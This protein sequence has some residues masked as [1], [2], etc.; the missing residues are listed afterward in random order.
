MKSYKRKIIVHFSSL[1]VD[2]QFLKY[3]TEKP[4]SYLLVWAYVYANISD[5]K[6]FTENYTFLLSRFKISR[7]TLQRIIDN[8]II[9][10]NS[11]TIGGQKVG[12][13][14][15]AKELIISVV[16]EDGGQKVGRKWA[17]NSRKKNTKSSEVY[18]AMIKL[19][20]DFCQREMGMG[21][22]IDGLQGKSMKSIISYLETQVK[23][24]QGE[25]EESVLNEEVI[26]AWTFI[27]TQWSSISDF[28]KAQIRLN[29]INSNL[30][31]IL[32]QLKNANSKSRA[33]KFASAAN[34][35]ANIS[36]E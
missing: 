3:L 4:H 27:L 9:F 7:T 28:Y 12:R 21:A 22:K 29:Q 25:I 24:K 36:F 30:P 2:K 10:L 16:T 34:A 31:N 15:A 19:Y 14:W 5:S 26:K 35:A 11:M 33:S 20:D 13:K 1:E 32:T 8:G 23:K 6:V 18:V 17:A